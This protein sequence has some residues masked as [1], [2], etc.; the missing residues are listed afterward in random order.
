[1]TRIPLGYWPEM[2]LPAARAAAAAAHARIRKGED[3]VRHREITTGTTFAAVRESFLAVHGRGL[4]KTT[5]EGYRAVL[6]RADVA[7]WDIRPINTITRAEVLRITDNLRAAGKTGMARKLETVLVG[8]FNFALERD[9]VSVNPAQAKVRRGRTGKRS[10]APKP[11]TRALSDDEIVTFWE[12]DRAPVLEVLQL[13]LKMI[14]VTGQRPGDVRLMEWRDVDLK[15]ASW[16]IPASK[17]KSGVAHTV[18]LSTLALDLMR[19]ARELGH[20][21]GFVFANERKPF[22]R[23]SLTGA[24]R[25]WFALRPDM[26]PFTGHDLRRSCRTG[27]SRIGISRDTAERCIGHV[28]GSAVERVYDTH[29][30]EREKREALEH[31]GAHVQGLV[32]LFT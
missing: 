13:L 1:M 10:D 18:P 11:R 9:M 14:L 30:Y 2:D 8:L 32:D 23:A 31:W 19:R 17:Y 5:L 27:M 12:M 16:R 21:D 29:S 22:H 6:T 20:H 4:R 15:T 7:R 26:V 24:L 25:T 28:V 3:P